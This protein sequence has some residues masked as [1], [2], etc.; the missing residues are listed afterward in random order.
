[1]FFLYENNTILLNTLTAVFKYVMK[2]ELSILQIHLIMECDFIN[3]IM[4]H[5]YNEFHILKEGN[6]N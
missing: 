6:N 5:T 4:E 3:E 2:N 1:M